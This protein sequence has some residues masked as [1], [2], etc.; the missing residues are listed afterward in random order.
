MTVRICN[1]LFYITHVDNLPSMLDN[2]ILSHSQLAARGLPST[3]IY[4]SEI[5]SNRKAKATPA[6]KTL[7]DYANLYFQP[8]NPMLYRVIDEKGLDSIAIISVQRTVLMLP[9]IFITDGNAASVATEFY[10]TKKGLEI[11]AGLNSTLSSEWWSEENGTKRKIMAECLVP[12]LIPST[13]I[14]TVYVAN[15]TIASRLKKA[16]DDRIP[17][18]AE[19]D[20][21]FLPTQ[22]ISLTKYLS[23]AQGDLFFSKMHTLTVSVNTVG[24]MGKGLA[25]RAKYQFPDVYVHYQDL[26]KRKTLAMGKPSIYKRESSLD[27]QMSDEPSKLTKPNLATWFLLFPTKNHWREKSDIKGIEAGLAWLAENYE[28]EKIKS[29]AI[30]ALG[31]GLGWLEWKDVGPLMVKY[32]KSMK[33]PV[34]LYLPAENKIKPEHLQPDYLL[35]HE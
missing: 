11:I 24:V 22:E 20:L 3:P 16:I 13:Y 17:V 9:D 28:K 23:L 21:F 6:G 26:C 35:G 18:I 31:C 33:I 14:Q 29:L 25:S 12:D 27:Y 5:V 15:Q 4:D 19:P 8:R 34:K 1:N 2:G 30:P 10:T 7:W 32:L